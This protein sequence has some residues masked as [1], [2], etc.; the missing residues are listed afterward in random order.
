MAMTSFHALGSLSVQGLE[1]DEVGR[2]AASVPV[3]IIL[4]C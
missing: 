2:E 3:T 1:R 4:R